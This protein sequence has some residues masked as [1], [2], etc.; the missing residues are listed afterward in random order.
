MTPIAY[1]LTHKG[2]AALSFH[3]MSDDFVPSVWD[4]KDA[5]PLTVAEATNVLSTHGKCG[6]DCHISRTARKV[7]ARLI[8]A[9]TVR[10]KAF[11]TR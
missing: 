2:E 8:D 6:A 11:R 10:A 7:R 9:P 4:C 5:G 3:P 1:L